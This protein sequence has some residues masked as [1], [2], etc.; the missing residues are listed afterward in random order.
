MFLTLDSVL[1]IQIGYVWSN[2]TIK[3]YIEEWQKVAKT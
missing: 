3:W 1:P 2:I